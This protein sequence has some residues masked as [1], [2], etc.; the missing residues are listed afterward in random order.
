MT[1]KERF[2]SKVM[3]EPNTG[4]WIWIGGSF[5]NGY[6]VFR[7]HSKNKKAHR[8]SFEFYK[9][10]IPDGMVVCHRCDNKFCVNPDHLF[11]GSMLDNV[12][13]M[14][15]KGRKHYPKGE[16]HGQ[17][18][19]KTADVIHIRQHAD[20]IG[21]KAIADKF[22]ISQKYIGEILRRHKWAHV[23]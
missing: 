6:G 21:H 10:S 14:I 11:L 23:S 7:I 20:S 1:H 12:T 17:S 16:L 5:E 13:D 4:C 22:G 18:K 9:G 2:E 15:S 8:M 19:L 3:P